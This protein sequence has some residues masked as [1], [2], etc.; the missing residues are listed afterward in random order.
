LA[1]EKRIDL[2]NHKITLLDIPI[3]LDE[4]IPSD[5]IEFRDASGGVMAKIRALAVP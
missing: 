2:L 5:T 4:S 3:E 1:D